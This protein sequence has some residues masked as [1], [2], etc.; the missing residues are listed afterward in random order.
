MRRNTNNS[1]SQ[2]TFIIFLSVAL[3]FAQMF[4]VHMHSQHHDDIP[5]EASTGHIVNVHVST[6]L[7]DTGHDTHHQDDFQEHNYH[8]EVDLSIDSF[9]KKVNSINLFALLFFIISF[10]LCTPQLRCVGKQYL[11]KLN[12]VSL[13]YLFQPPLR[14]P[15]K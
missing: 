6:S 14:A 12:P 8:A 7:H 1:V 10:V 15:P 11:L 2:Y 9:V 4:R 13:F 5:F 3:L